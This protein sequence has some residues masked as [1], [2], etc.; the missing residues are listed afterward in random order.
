MKGSKE[1]LLKFLRNWRTA[2]ELRGA[3]GI[4]NPESYVAELAADGY[5]IKTCQREMGQFSV[6]CYRW[7]GVKN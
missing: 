5:E 1:E 2:G 4:D 7:T 6:L 3:F